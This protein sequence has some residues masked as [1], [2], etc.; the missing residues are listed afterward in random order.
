MGLDELQAGH[1]WP[2]ATLPTKA[3]AL[4]CATSRPTTF[5]PLHWR[6]PPIQQLFISTCG[7]L[8]QRADSLEK[9]L[10]MGKIGGRRRKG[11]PRIRWLDGITDSRAMSLNK[12]QETVMDQETWS[13]DFSFQFREYKVQSLV[14]ELRSHISQN[15]K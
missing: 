3:Q 4:L 15:I 9:T 10:M 13:W 12:V 14:E 8:I 1:P 6:A 2:H 11:Q 5:E 7:H